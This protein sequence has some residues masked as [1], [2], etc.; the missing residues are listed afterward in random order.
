MSNFGLPGAHVL[1]AACAPAMKLATPMGQTVLMGVIFLFVF[2]A[3]IT[4]QGFA[5]KLYGDDLGSNVMLTLYATFTVACFIS[6]TVTNVLGAKNTLALGVLGYGAL[7]AASLLYSLP[8][9]HKEWAKIIV[10]LGGAILGVGAACLW[11]AQG[12]LLL[13]WADGENQ[14]TLFSV[15]WALFN[16][17]AL[18]G[19][20]LTFFYFSTTDGAVPPAASHPRGG[21]RPSCQSHKCPHHTHTSPHPSHLHP[22]AQSS[23][24]L[25]ESK[26]E[27]GF[28]V[29]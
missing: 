15:F 17:S 24:V 22:H 1:H 21:A 6:P 29:M 10:I 18:A 4:I 3:Y 9:F 16:T 19:G 14:G 12:R 27:C 5:S 13:E 11:T 25:T 8:A 2:A 7:V 23:V 20:L 26:R 28:R